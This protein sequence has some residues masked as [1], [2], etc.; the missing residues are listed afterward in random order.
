MRTATIGIVAV[1]ALVIAG[2]G[3]GAHFANKPRPATPVNLT[4]YINNS[5]V[6]VSP[7]S[8]GAGPVIFIITNQSSRTETVSFLPSA[9]GS[10]LASSAPIN[11]QATGQ[12]AINF[13]PGDYK[14]TTSQQAASDAA[15]TIP[16][17][18]QP[19][20]LHIGP[21]RQNANGVLLQP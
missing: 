7:N 12:V 13:S 14:V 20:L 6:S 21:P 16:S 3:G 9:G 2:C 11:P 1:S 5:R 17:S 15:Q 8:V 4:V 19:A 18:I 10:S